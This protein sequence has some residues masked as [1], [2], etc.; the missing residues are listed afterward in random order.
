MKIE[1][2]EL[3]RFQLP[4][5][6]PFR[7]SFGTQNHRDVILVR[8]ATDDSVGW[9]ECVVGVDPFYNEEYTDA[10]YEV[11]V[12]WLIP[13]VFA[14]GP[15]TA[16]GFAGVVANVVGNKGAKAAFEMALLD[17]Q[18]RA[19]GVSLT[20]YL[21]GTRSY[22]PVGVSIGITPTVD[23]LVTVSQGYVADGYA[24]LKLKIE[25][26]FDVEPV[27]RVREAVGDA[28]MLQ[29]DAN[30]AYTAADID[31]LAKLDE[32]NLLLI[33]QPFE[34][35]DLLTHAAMARKVSTPVCLDE[36]IVS[37]GATQNALE[38][39]ACSVVNVKVGRV[40][41]LLA[42][43][44]IHD[45]CADRGVP[46]WCGGML[47][48]GVGRAANVALASLPNFTLPGDISASARYF[49]RDITE[50]WVL[51]DS[52]LD[53]PQTPGLGVTVDEEFVARLGATRELFHP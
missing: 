32:F 34:P 16:E 2:V 13:M 15:L 19:E 7:T 27:R 21:G 6:R 40:G 42:S 41:G 36:S 50:P 12:R 48:T 25:P 35:D 43:R 45:L 5:V 33:E 28:V 18:L 20:S 24:R 22:V 1:A 52:S 23:D 38:L 51:R 37:V 3:L 4:L 49:D 9:G 44:D 31:H 46:V 17:A 14:H 8:V 26:G 11:L 29:V 47:E 53:V 39:A 10:A 30:A